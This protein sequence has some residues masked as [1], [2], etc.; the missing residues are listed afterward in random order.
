MAGIAATPAGNPASDWTVFFSGSTASALYGHPGRA[1][2]I[3]VIATA[4]TSSATL[5]AQI[6][7][8]V[9]HDQT[10][11]SGSR[12]GEAENSSAVYDRTDLF[13]L[14]ISVG[15]DVVLIALF[16]VASTVALSVSER[17]RTYALLRAVGATPGQVRRQVLAELGALGAFAGL[18]GVLPG[19]G[20]AR[21][22]MQGLIA[23]Q[24]MPPGAGVWTSGWLLLIAAGAGTIFAELAGYFASWRASRISPTGA[25][26]E[27]HVERRFPG[28]VRLSLGMLALAGGIALGVIT[29]TQ[30]L[31]AIN[32]LNLALAMGLAFLAAIGLLGP[33]LVAAAQLLVRLPVLALTGLP[34]RLALAEM[35]ARPRRMASA[36]V[37]V[38]LAVAFTSAVYLIDATQA[39]AAAAQARQRLTAE[40]VLSAPGPGLT[41]GALAAVRAV[42]GV[43]AAAGTTPTTVYAPYPGDETTAAEAVTPGPLTR[44]LNL[45]VID[46]SLRNFGT[47]DIALSKLVAGRDAIGA[48]VGE[49]ITVY[50]ADGTPYRAMVTAIYARSLGFADAVIPAGAA[51]GGHLGS[52]SLGEVLV[53]GSP[54]TPASVLAD[55][56]SKLASSYPGLQ[57]ASRQLVNAQDEL[58]NAQ[59]SYA[60]NLVLGL[61]AVLAGIALVNTLVMATLERRDALRLLQR[62]GTTN[63]QLVASTAWETILLAGSG[64]VLGAGAAATVIVVNVRALTGSMQPY[65]TW[66]P[67]AVILGLA[68]F[69]TGTATLA[70]TMKLISRDAQSAR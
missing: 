62:V 32:E 58:L 56:L 57:V 45:N 43:S 44:L 21:W 30:P 10:V 7:D 6:G 23:H 63:S 39:H 61:V 65:I 15:I 3:G 12:R 54:G 49:R 1:D 35:R 20:L 42:P 31:S 4:D 24:V 51:G 19:I 50:L 29:L 34:G 18:A 59:N 37:P 41:P 40:A 2:L 53:A 67:M 9:G 14:G 16:V 11:L 55:R 13:A 26:S 60:N 28:P 70:P 64:I 5:A 47:G 25:L 8:A 38:A 46:G 69:L 68:L 33:L 36:V 17:R 22:A 27:A 66:L 52:T 48:H